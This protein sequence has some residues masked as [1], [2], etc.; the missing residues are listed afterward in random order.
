LNSTIVSTYATF[1]AETRFGDI[2]K[3]VI[4]KAREALVDLLGVA[5]CGARKGELSP[6]VIEMIEEMG[7]TPSCLVIGSRLRADSAMAA[8]ANSVSSHSIELDDGHR[9]G[10]S[11][12]AVVI[13]PVAMAAAEETGAGIKDLI[14]AIVLGYEIMLRIATAI[15]PSHLSRGFHST[16]TCGPLGAAVAAAC[17]Y[18][19]MPELPIAVRLFLVGTQPTI[20]LSGK[21]TILNCCFWLA[22]KEIFP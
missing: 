9:H 11:H 3:S 8:L 1:V 15:N 7:T 21:S 18:R 5:L 22:G 6:I 17:L 19:Q 13:I 16:G 14:R 20:R 2:P 10:T 4:Q 12:P